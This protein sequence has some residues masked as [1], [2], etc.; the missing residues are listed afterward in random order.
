MA[1]YVKA[2]RRTDGVREAL[3]ARYQRLA[4]RYPMP[5]EPW[6]RKIADLDAGEPV[7][8]SGWE[9]HHSLPEVDRNTVYTV[10][11]AGNLTLAVIDRDQPAPRHLRTVRHSCT[12]ALA[13]ILAPLRGV[14]RPEYPSPRVSVRVTES[15]TSPASSSRWQRATSTTD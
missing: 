13:G 3:R 2:E 8:V 11:A 4:D 12:R 9:L 15:V 6:T 5:G 7:I 14:L 10:D 1:R